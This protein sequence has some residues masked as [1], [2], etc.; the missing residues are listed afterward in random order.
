MHS[1]YADL[2]CFSVKIDGAVAEVVISHGELNLLDRQM[3]V[4]LNSLAEFL[5]EDTRVKVIVF[6]SGIPNFFIAHADLSLILEAQGAEYDPAEKLV[7]MNHIVERFRLMPKVCI[8]QINGQALGGGMEFAIGLDMCFASDSSR[9]GQP[10]VALGIIPGGG[11]T[12]R[13]PDKVGRNRALEI[14]LSS[15]TY[16]ATEAEQYGYINR[17]LPDSDIAAFVDDLA[18]RIASY[19]EKAITAVKQLVNGQEV[20][21]MQSRL[22]KEQV[23]FKEVSNSGPAT[24]RMNLALE[25]GFQTTKVELSDI[26]QFLLE[27]NS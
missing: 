1:T 6:R 15:K 21:S 18:K 16:S 7:L 17:A 25:R 13:L 2:D 11:G 23:A 22:L 8:A 4:E 26:D 24:R 14:L 5:E 3:M 9:V 20:L 10:E 19:T 27:L 12:S